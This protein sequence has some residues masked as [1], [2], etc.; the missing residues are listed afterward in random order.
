MLFV[1]KRRERLHSGECRGTQKLVVP[2][3]RLGI[4]SLFEYFLRAEISIRFR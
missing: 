4:Y 3:V 1:E 2:W